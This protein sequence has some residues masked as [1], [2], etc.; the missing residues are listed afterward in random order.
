LI[1]REINDVAAGR[2]DFFNHCC[3]RGV[4]KLY[5]I[6][7][8]PTRSA[9]RS[10]FMREI[11]AAGMRAPDAAQRVALRGAVRCRAGA[12]QSTGVWYGPGSAKQRFAKGYAP[13]RARDTRIS[14]LPGLTRQSIFFER[15]L[16][17]WMDTRVKPAYDAAYVAAS[18]L[19]SEFK[20]QTAKPL[21]SRG[22]KRP[23]F[24]S[25]SRTARGDGA[26]GGARAPMGTL[27][28]GLTYPPRAAR[29][30]RAP[31]ARRSA[32]QRSTGLSTVPGR[33]GPASFR[34][35][36]CRIAS[37]KRPFIGIELVIYTAM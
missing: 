33:P 2:Y 37:R 14:S 34:S 13:H 10:N 1:L 32:S 3:P 25:P 9:H 12:V 29:Q 22:A 15:V 31:K 20:F 30:P 35:V 4:D 7:V 24:A 8:S 23:R 18:C 27:E 11:V 26:V 6:Q 16:R 19:I 17:R 5:G 21:R 28:A 36:R